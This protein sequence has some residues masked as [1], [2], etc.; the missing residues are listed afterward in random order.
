MRTILLYFIV[1]ITLP[2]VLTA[3]YCKG[4]FKPTKSICK[5]FQFHKMK[6]LHGQCTTTDYKK[7]LIGI[8]LS[9]C[10]T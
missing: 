5:K 10:T 4:N 1:L 8:K 7:K 9:N 6:S 3:S 2:Y